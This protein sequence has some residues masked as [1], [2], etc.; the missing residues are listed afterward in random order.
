M[1]RREELL[2]E[3]KSRSCLPISSSFRKMLSMEMIVSQIFELTVRQ[4]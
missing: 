3:S 2:N 4:R 1:K